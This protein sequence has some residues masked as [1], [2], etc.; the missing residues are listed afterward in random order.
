MVYSIHDR[1]KCLMREW[2]AL[3]EKYGDGTDLSYDGLL[4]RGEIFYE[5]G[6]WHRKTGEEESQWQRAKHRL[7]I[8]T[9]DINDDE[10]WDIRQETGRLNKV[11]YSYERAIPFYKNLRMWSYGL[12]QSVSGVFPTFDEA[13]DMSRSGPFYETAPIARVNCKKQAG[14]SSIADNV[15]M[16]YIERYAV[17]LK[18]QIDL[19]D[20]DIILCCGYS[21]NRNIIM[22]FVKSQCLT[23][24]VQVPDTGNWIYHSPSTSKLVINSYHPS[25]RI[26]YEET[27]CDM[28]YSL[29]SGLDT[30]G[31]KI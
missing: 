2:Q 10:A 1:E 26:G 31:L 7:L 27:Y 19:Y 20:A 28:I 24:L 4:F 9:K 11:A 5:K 29:K 14:G 23:D 13:R 3:S 30:V 8:L 6:C 12:L 25:A 21:G 22:D 15:L 16:D 17:L 18:K